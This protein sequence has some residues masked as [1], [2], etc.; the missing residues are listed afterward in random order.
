M[1]ILLDIDNKSRNSESTRVNRG[2]KE[3][4]KPLLGRKTY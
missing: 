3:E 1:P 4:F 2:N